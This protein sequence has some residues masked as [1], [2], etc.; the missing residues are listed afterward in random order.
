[1][2]KD[3][4]FDRHLIKS[5]MNQNIAYEQLIV[6]MYRH[7]ETVHCLTENDF[8]YKEPSFQLEVS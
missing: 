1:M 5:S 8:L 3:I 2:K 7:A 4:N 6:E